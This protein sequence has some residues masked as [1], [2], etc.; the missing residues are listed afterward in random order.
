MGI[1]QVLTAA[2]HIQLIIQCD[3]KGAQ[4]DCAVER[5]RCWKYIFDYR[6]VRREFR[7]LRISRLLLTAHSAA[8]SHQPENREYFIVSSK[9]EKK[10]QK[11]TE[12]IIYRPIASRTKWICARNFIINDLKFILN[13]TINSRHCCNFSFPIWHELRL[14]V[15]GVSP[16]VHRADISGDMLFCRCF[17]IANTEKT[18]CSVCRAF[19]NFSAYTQHHLGWL[20]CKSYRAD[21]R[22]C[23]QTVSPYRV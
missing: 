8:R 11:R 6:V 10:I 20:H 13:E 16:E 23:V 2:A 5:G 4:R 12:L 7:K 1:L 18:D 9:S 3:P 21:R 19:Q 14:L 15:L 17:A 22:E